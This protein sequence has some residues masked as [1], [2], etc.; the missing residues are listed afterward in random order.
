MTLEAFRVS[1]LG[2]RVQNPNTRTRFLSN[3]SRIFSLSRDCILN[4]NAKLEQHCPP[5]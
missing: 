5:L 4:G 2:F 3:H 1:G